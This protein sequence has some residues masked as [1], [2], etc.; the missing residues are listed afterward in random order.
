MSESGKAKMSLGAR[1]AAEREAERVR[2]K[3]GFPLETILQ[4]A[5]ISQRERRGVGAGHNNIPKAYY[6]TP[7][8]IKAILAFSIGNPLKGYRMP[9]YEMID[10][11]VATGF[12]PMCLAAAS[13]TL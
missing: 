2:A 13:I 4:Y 6:L 3:T 9:R 1:E 7:E 5:G 11:N 12:S 10:R 8:E